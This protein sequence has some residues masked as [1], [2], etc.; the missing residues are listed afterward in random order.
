MRIETNTR[1]STF[2]L[3]MAQNPE[4]IIDYVKRIN[5]QKVSEKIVELLKDK[6]PLTMYLEFDGELIH[7]DDS[8][9]CAICTAVLCQ[10]VNY[11]KDCPH[12]IYYDYYTICKRDNRR[13]SPYDFCSLSTDDELYHPFG[14]GVIHKW[15]END[16]HNTER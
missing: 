16:E 5:N 10:K 7:H 11:C 4:D 2:E 8:D 9:D 13:M 12:G 1:V 3:Q 6:K 15:E 14:V